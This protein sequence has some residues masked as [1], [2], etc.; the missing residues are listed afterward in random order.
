MTDHG[1]QLTMPTVQALSHDEFLRRA[2][3]QGLLT[4]RQYA[5]EFLLRYTMADPPVDIS[6]PTLAK[7]FIELFGM[8]GSDR[9][10]AGLVEDARV[11]VRKP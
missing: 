2:H 7:E 11:K 9:A 3:E 5:G 1:D 6:D 4:D 8:E 10:L